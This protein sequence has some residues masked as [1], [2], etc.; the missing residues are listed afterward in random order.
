M[1]NTISLG[2]CKGI[3]AADWA[4][5]LTNIQANSIIAPVVPSRDENLQL[6]ILGLS[7][8]NT[9]AF[10]YYRYK[11]YSYIHKRFKGKE[12]TPVDFMT[13]TVCLVQHSELLWDLIMGVLMM[14]VANG[15]MDVNTVMPLFCPFATHVTTFMWAHSVSGGLCIA[16]YRIMLIKHHHLVNYV[17]GKKRLLY[18]ILFCEILLL[19]FFVVITTFLES[20]WNPLRPPCFHLANESVLEYIDAY[21]QTFGN[22]PLS[23]SLVMIKVS[24]VLLFLML[25]FT[26][27]IIYFNIFL[28]L[29]KHDNKEILKKLLGLEQIKKRNMRNVMSFASSF[30]SF[31]AEMSLLILIIISLI[32][33]FNKLVPVFLRK[34]TLTIM[35][36]IEVKT[37]QN[38]K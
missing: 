4:M 17:I 10:T 23:N 18:I 2:G 37:S 27:I 15:Y 13:L 14:S 38:L 16:I 20:L 5:K 33:S 35:A 3:R 29:Y 32:S 34:F 12:L 1:N 6:L 22:P 30:F 24:L 7:W 31:L 8:T 26:E 28:H 19:G 9:A 25:T 11:V 21:N 36:I